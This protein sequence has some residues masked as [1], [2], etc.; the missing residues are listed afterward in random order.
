MTTEPA[1]PTT[2][3]PA[4][5]RAAAELPKKLATF[6]DGLNDVERKVMSGVIWRSLP[7]VERVQ[8][9]DTAVGFSELELQMLADLESDDLPKGEPAK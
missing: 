8:F 4:E 6:Y 1:T 9:S 2:Y 3:G 7:P 5:G